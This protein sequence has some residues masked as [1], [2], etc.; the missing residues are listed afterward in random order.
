MLPPM[1]M[2]PWAATKKNFCISVEVIL[3]P[4]RVFTQRPL[5]PIFS[6]VEG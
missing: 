2:E 5:V 3:A 1:S 6:S 4:V